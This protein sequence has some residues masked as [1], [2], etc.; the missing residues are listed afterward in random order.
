[1]YNIGPLRRLILCKELNFFSISRAPDK[2]KASF[3]FRKPKLKTTQ[4]I[5]LHRYLFVMKKV[6]DHR[7]DKS[8]RSVD[9]NSGRV[10]QLVSESN[11]VLFQF[12]PEPSFPAESGL[13][14]ITVPGLVTS[15]Y[16]ES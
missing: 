3:F 11:S 4:T 9:K 2:S 15:S 12:L 1:M 13:I 8:A 16:S 10:L 7:G 14:T 5:F 6:T